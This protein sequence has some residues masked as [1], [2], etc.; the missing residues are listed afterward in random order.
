MIHPTPDTNSLPAGRRLLVLIAVVLTAVIVG[1]LAL[2]LSRF[3]P[4][5]TP[6]LRLV[7][8]ASPLEELTTIAV[9][10][11]G[12]R[13][14]EQVA[15]CLSQGGADPCAAAS[16]VAITPADQAGAIETAVVASPQLAQGLTTFV[17]QGLE[18]GRSA[19]RTFRALK[20]P[21]ARATARATSAM[22]S[23][24]VPA[25]RDATAGTPTP[26][27]APAGWAAEYFANPDLAGSPVVAR[28][29]SALDFDWGA[30]SPDPRLPADGFSARWVRRLLFQGQTYRFLAQMDGG[31]RLTIDGALLIDQW[32]DDGF[33]TTAS[34]SITLLPGEHELR[35]EYVDLQGNAAVALRWEA[36]DL[37]PDWRGEYFANPE[38]AGEP[39]LVRN[40]PDPVQDWGEASPVPSI[41][42][43]DGFS[44]RWTRTLV[45]AAGLYRFALTADDGGQILV[46]GQTVVDAWSGPSGQTVTADR[47]LGEGPHQVI[48]LFR[49]LAGPARIA[50]GW[51]PLVISTSAPLAGLM[52]TATPA[53]G[54]MPSDLPTATPGMETATPAATE[55]AA[56]TS[57]LTASVT[58][59]SGTT[60]P[61]ATPGT[62]TATP[63]VAGPPMTPPNSAE[64]YIEIDPNV[65]PPGV[66]IRISS[67]NW[68]P[69]ALVQVALGRA[70]TPYTEAVDLPGIIFTTP[71]IASMPFSF[72]F[73][74]PD[75]TPWSN[76]IEPVQI[77]LHDA[78]WTEWGRDLFVVE[79]R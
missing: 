64:R 48:V 46:D 30:G 26:P 22:A 76:Q 25:D 53:P 50:A 32:G 12:W 20:I 9:S 34:A 71:S 61:Q 57:S 38:L 60:T 19:S 14:G 7:P 16:A 44:V 73:T 13:R 6:W 77:W 4:Q 70:N 2:F 52:P 27:A 68:S 8:A 72:V 35:V 10:G 47:A 58:A 1:L 66:E 55:S 63:P 17:A 59:P 29:E 11:G 5:P 51:S 42:P 78:D 36:V 74:F 54:S 79:W 21:P 43:P 15:I 33:P 62:P 23:G 69:G 67:V 39:A 24:N 45:F 40:D 28:A 37:F 56:P 65:G 75:E 49:D 3:G 41:I 31:L 18:S